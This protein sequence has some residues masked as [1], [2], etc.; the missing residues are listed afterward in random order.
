MRKRLLSYRCEVT[1]LGHI[2]FEQGFEIHTRLCGNLGDRTLLTADDK[3]CGDNKFAYRLVRNLVDT[4]ASVGLDGEAILKNDVGV[5]TAQSFKARS[6][7]FT[8]NLFESPLDVTD[9]VDFAR[10]V[11]LN[12]ID[13]CRFGALIISV[14]TAVRNVVFT[15]LYELCSQVRKSEI[16]R[17]CFDLFVRG[18]LENHHFY[19]I[20]G[21]ID[22]V[23]QVIDNDSVDCM[24]FKTESR[25]CVDKGVTRRNVIVRFDIQRT[26]NALRIYATHGVERE[27]VRTL[28]PTS[29]ESDI[30][31]AYAL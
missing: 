4:D 30:R 21:I 7:A 25:R 28:R 9:I 27:S 1:C 8:I 12:L 31:A 26:G 20:F 23:C 6:V 14:N 3:S 5:I 17:V 18:R 22:T 11:G 15:A 2:D 29:N 10:F 13:L 24:I 16:S 19:D